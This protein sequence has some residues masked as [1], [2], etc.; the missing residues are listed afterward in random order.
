MGRS[1]LFLWVSDASQ[2]VLRLIKKGDVERVIEEIKFIQT[3]QAKNNLAVAHI[4]Q[5][6]FKL[7]LHLLVTLGDSYQQSAAIMSNLM[8]LFLCLNKI[9]EILDMQETTLV[10]ELRPPLDE[11]TRSILA[12]LKFA[13]M[14][15][16]QPESAESEKKSEEHFQADEADEV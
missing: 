5:G 9:N 15:P 1:P 2:E 10:K 6:E 7:A 13:N 16:Q 12:L 4:L 3:D 14:L 8:F 11:Q